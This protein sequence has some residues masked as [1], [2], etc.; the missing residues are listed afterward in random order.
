MGPEH[1]SDRGAARDEF[2]VAWYT[3][4]LG[5]PLQREL[6][7]RRLNEIAPGHATP[8]APS[9]GQERPREPHDAPPR[10]DRA[11]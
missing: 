5:R 3:K 4:E 10:E 11:G 6:L 1:E 2:E 7:Q 9:N 8:A